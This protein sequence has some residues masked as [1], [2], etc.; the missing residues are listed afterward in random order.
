[1]SVDSR[2]ITG[3][4]CEKDDQFKDTAYPLVYIGCV[5]VAPIGV[6]IVVLLCLN[7]IT[8]CTL[9]GNDFKCR[10]K[11]VTCNISSLTQNNVSYLTSKTTLQNKYGTK[12]CS[13]RPND[14]FI[15]S[16]ESHTESARN[17]L[18]PIRGIGRKLASK[19][20]N[21][22]D[23]EMVFSEA[24]LKDQTSTFGI[25]SVGDG[26]EVFVT[27]TSVEK[28]DSTD[29]F[30]ENHDQTLQSSKGMSSHKTELNKVPVVSRFSSSSKRHGEIKRVKRKTIIMLILTTV[31]A[32][33]MTM[34]VV[35]TTVIADK[36]N[37]LQSLSNNEKV[38]FF[39]FYRLYFINT[40][41]NPIL[42][43]ILDQRFRK[44]L[45]KLLSRRV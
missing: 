34:Y 11:N 12:A 3:Y 16:S 25:E 24:H 13:L 36:H 28:C 20:K 9:F 27:S 5:Y 29:D 43:G 14:K 30:P 33:T 19:N 23:N 26:D 6:M 1:M 18:C 42:Y 17:K 32:I 2:N 40:N 39:F 7:C 22:R 41:I 44:G 21:T 35:L 15:S 31:F 4:I 45:I 8:V 38:V 37:I 10:A